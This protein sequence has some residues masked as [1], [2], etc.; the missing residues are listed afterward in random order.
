MKII[1]TGSTGMVGEGVL[2]ECLE[3][4]NVTSVLSI[5]RKPSGITHPRLKELLVDDFIKIN[6]YSDQLS[7]FD[8]CFY[9]AGISSVGMTEEKYQHITY[10]TTISFAGTLLKI[11]PDL[12]FIFVSGAS[13]DSTGEGKIMW[14]RIKGKTEN[15]LGKMAF[16]AQY[17]F[18]PGLMKPDKRQVH[19]KGINKYI[20]LLYPLLGLF[21]TG[22]TTK[23][24]GRAMIQA[25]K[26]GFPKITLEA[27]DIKKLSEQVQ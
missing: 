19:L 18:R 12:T 9:C 16:K 10:D 11:N 22:S 2:L 3:N 26:T 5:S 23:K 20:G 14:A 8:A 6:Q 1:I 17:N 21:Y 15:A 24:I 7:G 4:D 25:V 27:A 13:T